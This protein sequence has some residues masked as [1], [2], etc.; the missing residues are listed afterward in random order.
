MGGKFDRRRP[1][2]GGGVPGGNHM[3][4]GS[5]SAMSVNMV[6]LKVSISPVSVSGMGPGCDRRELDGDQ[7]DSRSNYPQN[8]SGRS[9][10][11]LLPYGPSQGN[12]G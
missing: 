11:P 10:A 9:H 12:N 7:K 8:C 1:I 4:I 5:R 2:R 3:G 6:P